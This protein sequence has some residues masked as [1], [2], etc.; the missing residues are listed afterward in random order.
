MKKE[1][2][3]PTIIGVGFLLISVF[4][5]VKYS[6]RTTTTSS[7]ASG[8]CQPD[9]V[10]ITNLTH[11]SA[12]LSFLT[13]S[14]CQ[15]TVSL[16]N[17]IIKDL[18][19]ETLNIPELSSRIHYFF[20]NNLKEKTTYNYSI[21]SGG[22]TYQEK[23]Y[24]F[25]TGSTP[26]SGTPNSNLAWGKVFSP[27]GKTPGN[28]LVFLNISGAYPLSS[29]VTTNGNWSI[30]LA[31]SFNDTQTNWFTLS[32]TVSSE[33]IIVYSE[34]GVF[35]QVTNS[36]SRNNPVPDIIIGTNSLDTTNY[37]T[38][39]NSSTGQVDSIS[40]VVDQKKVD[41]ANPREGDMLNVLRP[42]FFGSAPNSTQVIIEVH[43]DTVINGQTTSDT[44]GNWHWSPPQNLEPGQHTITVKSL[45]KNTGIWETITRSFTVLASDNLSSPNFEA[46]GS[47]ST[48]S[49]AATLVSTLAP[50]KTPVPTIRT[51]HPSTTIQ[52]PVTANYLP[53]IVI[54]IF[55]FLF[56]LISFKLL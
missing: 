1:F 12:S 47:A 26:I 23:S 20:I 46:S 40:P 50:T 2:K 45:N 10:Q 29:M 28:A 36:T 6:T 38:A 15:S 25:I 42:D 16:D 52:P 35:T 53:T 17:Q 39:K 7:N 3:F 44:S 41:I 19:A 43:S 56:I 48:P 34:D 14:K 11:N 30:S 31:S 27:D 33:D 37:D 49:P 24:S 13:S 55:S 9:N 22:S 51:A 8:S 5:G 54:F 4:V 18:K 32:D 21:I